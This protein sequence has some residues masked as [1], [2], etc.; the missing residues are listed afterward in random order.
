MAD[1]P[2]QDKESLSQEERLYRSIT[3][4]MRK[5]GRL[6]A[7]RLDRLRETRNIEKEINTKG[8]EGKEY[9]KELTHQESIQRRSTE[10][11]RDWLLNYQLIGSSIGRI[12]KESNDE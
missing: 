12:I 7:E 1:A 3:D 6:D 2:R 5:Q 4:E 8:Y 10:H 11:L 9:T